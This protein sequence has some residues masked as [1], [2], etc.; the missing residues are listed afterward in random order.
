[1]RPAASCQSR[2]GPRSGICSWRV[3][4]CTID[5]KSRRLKSSHANISYAV[6]C[7]KKKKNT[8]RTDQV[9]RVV[10]TVLGQADLTAEL[11]LVG[12]NILVAVR[13]GGIHRRYTRRDR[14][15]VLVRVE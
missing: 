11:D 2:S 14:P 8:Q 13:W 5:R 15:T 9:R 6:F 7:L 3:P 12:D 1:M 4:V 10:R